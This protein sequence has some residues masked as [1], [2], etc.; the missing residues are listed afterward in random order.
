MNA[1][2]FFS[3]AGLGL[4]FPKASKVQ[5]QGLTTSVPNLRFPSG[6]SVSCTSSLSVQLS[7]CRVEAVLFRFKYGYGREQR[8]QCGTLSLKNYQVV[9]YFYS[10]WLL[11]V[12]FVSK[13]LSGGGCLWTYQNRFVVPVPGACLLYNLICVLLVLLV[14]Q[15]SLSSPRSPFSSAR[16]LV[17]TREIPELVG[18]R[19]C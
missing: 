5:S 2:D 6:I 12:F 7:S 13:I 16:K 17:F 9:Q 10:K 19:L 14:I 4:C 3:L 18:V 15:M 11:S 8:H 1:Q